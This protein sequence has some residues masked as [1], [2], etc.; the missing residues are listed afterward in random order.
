MQ[1]LCIND[2]QERIRAAHTS[3]ALQQVRSDLFGKKGLISVAL[4]DLKT[5]SDSGRRE[6]SLHLN[7]IKSA[8]LEAMSHQQGLIEE[9]EWQKKLEQEAIDVTLPGPLKPLGRGHPLMQVMADVVEIFSSMG[10]SVRRGPDIETEFYNFDAL[11]VPSDHPARDEQDTF[12][13]PKAHIL[14]TQT[15]PVQIRTM[16][17]ESLP[18]RI[19]SPGRVYRSDHDRTHTPMF[20]Q[21]EG[22]VV[23]PGIHMGH[24]KGCLEK[25]LGAFF[26]SEVKTRLR[27]SFFP[28]TE[29]S[30]EVDIAYTR[31]EGRLDIGRG[32]E[33]LEILGCGMVHK[34]VFRSCGL[35]EETQGFAFGAGLERLAMLKYGIEDIRLLFHNDQRWLDHYGFPGSVGAL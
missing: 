4:R 27:P 1:S 24:L 18:L 25:F 31:R 23:E 20:H 8:A 10:F 16:M 33:W 35:S 6:H 29:P 30:A 11:N 22:L 21:I 14:R 19:I 9:K 12:Y 17:T 2:I 3:E 7:T 26:G 34:N 13:L 28:F 15:S 5:L 32:S